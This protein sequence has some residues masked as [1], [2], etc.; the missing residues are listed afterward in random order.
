MVDT[1]TQRSKIWWTDLIR[2][3]TSRER[4][5]FVRFITDSDHYFEMQ[6]GYELYSSY[7]Q[8]QA[9]LLTH[10]GAYFISFTPAVNPNES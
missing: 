5:C 3:L 6:V 10:R 7:S 2:R 9:G 8:D 1:T 4:T